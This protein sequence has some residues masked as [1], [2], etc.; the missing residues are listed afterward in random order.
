MGC[1]DIPKE[2]T[3]RFW[4]AVAAL[5]SCRVQDEEEEEMSDQAMVGQAGQGML[6][7]GDSNDSTDS[8]AVVGVANVHVDAVLL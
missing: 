3:G 5:I 7:F 1:D 2:L 8:Q 6:A 4:S